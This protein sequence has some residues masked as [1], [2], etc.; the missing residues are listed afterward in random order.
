MQEFL[1]EFYTTRK[2]QLINKKD[3]L[4]E[5][6]SDD[7]QD[8]LEESKTDFI[9]DRIDIEKIKKGL[10]LK[11]YNDY[12]EEIYHRFNQKRSFYYYKQWIWMQFPWIS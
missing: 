3:H 6:D 10:L 7:S 12:S 8:E 5:E 4:L 11:K 9:V 1:D 2:K